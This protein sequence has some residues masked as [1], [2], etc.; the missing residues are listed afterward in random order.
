MRTRSQ[1]RV[2]S[3]APRTKPMDSVDAAFGSEVLF[4]RSGASASLLSSPD[5]AGLMHRFTDKFT[6]TFDAR[7][8]RSL[9]AGA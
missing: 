9:L 4:G 2:V 8:D 1:E 5:A 3:V 6:R 7:F